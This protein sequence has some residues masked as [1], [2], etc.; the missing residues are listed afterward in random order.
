MVCG[1]GAVPSS[2][3]LHCNPER[4]LFSIKGFY[5]EYLIFC[6]K[7]L[8]KC[9]AKYELIKMVDKAA[10]QRLSNVCLTS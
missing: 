7:Y 10:S 6:I 3:A 9:K 5:F 8:F 4:S 1:E 2:N